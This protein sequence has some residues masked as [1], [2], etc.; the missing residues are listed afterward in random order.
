NFSNI[1]G[2][3]RVLTEREALPLLDNAVTSTLIP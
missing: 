1:F 2:I 3:D